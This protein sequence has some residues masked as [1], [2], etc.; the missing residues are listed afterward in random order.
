MTLIYPLFWQ[1]LQYHCEQSEDKFYLD[2]DWHYDI[3]CLIIPLPYYIVSDRVHRFTH[4][5]NKKV[6]NYSDR[7]NKVYYS[8][9]QSNLFN[10]TKIALTYFSFHSYY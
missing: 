9:K 7:Q 2:N 6:S 10:S 5:N 3:N 8:S 1:F 4:Q